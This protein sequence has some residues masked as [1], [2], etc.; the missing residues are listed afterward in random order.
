[1]I[2]YQVEG[3]GNSFQEM[4]NYL[5][6]FPKILDS[7]A[8]PAMKGV[9]AKAQAYIEPRI[10]VRT[11]AA[12]SAFFG[13][14]LGYGKTLTGVVGFRGGKGAPYHINI[15]EHGARAHSLVKGSKQRTR[16][17]FSRFQKR[18][19]RGSIAGAHVDINGRWVTMTIHPGVASRGFMAAGFQ[20]VK[21]I[22]NDEMQ[23][24]VDAAF[25]EVKS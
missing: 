20:H 25:S 3:K 16:A 7:H 2:R 17:A 11:G 19:E 18:A 1:M 9:V 22:L 4:V 23:K 14:V 10:P 21:P 8:F 6:Q 5:A 24:A 15:I 13:E 12:K